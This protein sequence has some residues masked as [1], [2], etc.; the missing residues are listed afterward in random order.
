MTKTTR[1]GFSRGPK[2]TKHHLNIFRRV[3]IWREQGWDS[4]FSLSLS[5]VIHFHPF[6]SRKSYYIE[7]HIQKLKRNGWW[8]KLMHYLLSYNRSVLETAGVENENDLLTKSTKSFSQIFLL[9]LHFQEGFECQ[10]CPGYV[11]P[12][13]EEKDACYPS[14]CKN[15]GICVDLSQGHEGSTFQCLCPYG[16]F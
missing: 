4:S 10:C 2:Q 5:A 16:K 13:C 14:P 15:N 1:K 12:H 3:N 11:G 7:M 9:Y 6:P 8:E